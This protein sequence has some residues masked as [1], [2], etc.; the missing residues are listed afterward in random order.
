MSVQPVSRRAKER[1]Q[2]QLR[3]AE[4][5]R[6]ALVEILARGDFRDPGLQDVSVTVSEVKV[7]PD[8]KNATVFVMPLGGDQVDEVVGSLNRAAPFLRRQLG[9]VVETRYLP[10]LS[11]EKDT[12]YDNGDRIE[13]L[14]RSLGVSGDLGEPEQGR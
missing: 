9:G 11:F 13:R 10:R 14:L 5:L 1:T 6:H 4:M 2:R 3:V 7:S 12:T 8:L